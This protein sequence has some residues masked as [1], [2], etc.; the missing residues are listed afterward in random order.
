MRFRL[1]AT[2]AATLCLLSASAAAFPG[3]GTG[4]IERGRAIF[5]SRCAI[6]HGEDGRGKDGMAANLVEEWHRLTKSDS[7]LTKSIRS[8]LRTQ[9]KNYNAGS[10]PPQV[11][12]DRDMEDLLTHVRSAF[13]GT[14]QFNPST[15]PL[16]APAS[17]L[18]APTPL[19][20]P[21]P[22]FGA[23]PPLGTPH[24]P[25]GTPPPLGR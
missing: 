6:C 17:P 23:P 24:T 13:G 11:V 14:A 2:L 4:N 12:S 9:G 7:E 3:A 8:G 22:P 5:N 1:H 21:Q 20:G 18:G 19:G 25:F 16:G 15:A 10:C